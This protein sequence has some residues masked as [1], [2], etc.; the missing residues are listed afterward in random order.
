MSHSPILEHFAKASLIPI[1][2]HIEDELLVVSGMFRSS[3]ITIGKEFNPSDGDRISLRRR[4]LPDAVAKYLAGVPKLGSPVAHANWDGYPLLHLGRE[5]YGAG[6]SVV[7][8][9]TRT[10]SHVISRL[11]AEKRLGDAEQRLVAKGSLAN[12]T[13]FVRKARELPEELPEPTV[14][15]A[16]PI[17]FDPAALG[18]TDPI[19]PGWLFAF[20]GER[21]HDAIVSHGGGEAVAL[22]LRDDPPGPYS[23]VSTPQ[24]ALDDATGVPRFIRFPVPLL[25]LPGNAAPEAVAMKLFAAYPRL[26]GTAAP[27][28]Q[29]RVSRSVRDLDGGY[30]IGLQQYFGGLQVIGC[31]LVVHMTPQLAITSVSGRYCREPWTKLAPLVAEQV[32]AARASAHFAGAERRTKA[33]PPT[34]RG[35][36]ILPQRMVGA[37]R[38]ELVWWFG[39]DD[40]DRFISATDGRLVTTCSRRHDASMV[41]DNKNQAGAWGTNGELQIENGMAVV[42]R[43]AAEALTTAEALD[44]L[45]QFWVAVGSNSWNGAGGVSQVNLNA[46]EP[47]TA[48]AFW[49]PANSTGVSGYVLCKA[50]EAQQDVIS[51][52]FIHG[53]AS[54]WGNFF[55]ESPR[56]EPSAL[57]E[58]FSDVLGKFVIPTPSPWTMENKRDLDR[59][60]I[61]KYGKYD[62]NGDSHLNCGIGNLIAVRIALGDGTPAHPGL[63]SQRMARLWWDLLMT[64]M[65]PRAHYIDLALNASEVA[66]QLVNASATGVAYPPGGPSPPRFNPGDTAIV[67]WALREAGLTPALASGWFQVPGDREVT[68]TINAG[69]SCP[70]EYVVED[71]I[72]MI[73][74]AQSVKVNYVGTSMDV[75]SLQA[76]TGHVSDTFF[77]GNIRAEL[78]APT[79][80]QLQQVTRST[81]V[82][83]RVSTNNYGL[84]YV[85]ATTPLRPIAPTQTGLVTDW[86]ATPPVARWFDNPFF[87]GRKYGD[88]VYEGEPLPAGVTIDSVVLVLLNRDGTLIQGAVTQ[89][90]SPGAVN[91]G[92]GA[93]IFSIPDQ[94]GSLEVRVRSWHDFGTAVRWRLQYLITSPPGFTLPP[95]SVREAGPYGL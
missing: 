4:F 72:A 48:A 23:Q 20:S 73:E 16:R 60:Q 78:L 77:E 88:V 92:R 62:T 56:S 67:T 87:A 57:A 35:L 80:A 93:W 9:D 86:Y 32:A 68:L 6:V 42:S 25:L 33:V 29:L 82:Q 66:R 37:S 53:A 26:F 34:R 44:K 22:I 65:T 71:A 55:T 13:A 64:R 3:S 1:A 58:C 94:A 50:G 49:Q 45:D 41:Y 18:S 79:Q 5:V 75:G 74:Q 70:Q 21:G 83:I 8:S 51:H 11:P 63:G 28:D 47:G 17:W 19:V 59:P 39:F 95:F 38:D 12:A 40:A 30:H 54:V 15:S 43:P 61:A 84:V 14:P 91:S 36:A 89:L 2:F 46:N 69:Q 10:V 24:Y 52:E 76:S 90:G 27:A 81:E 7:W 85:S 31:E